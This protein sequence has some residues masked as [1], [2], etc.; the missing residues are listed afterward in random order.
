MC[1]YTYNQCTP[2]AAKLQIIEVIKWWVKW[3]KVIETGCNPYLNSAP[4]SSTQLFYFFQAIKFDSYMLRPQQGNILFLI[5]RPH[6]L[7]DSSTSE[8]TIQNIYI[9]VLLPH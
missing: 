5:Y 9:Y 7:P 3:R 6:R 1:S 4:F 2:P 8:N